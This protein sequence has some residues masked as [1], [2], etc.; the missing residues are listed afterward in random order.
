M[1]WGFVAWWRIAL[2]LWQTDTAALLL[3]WVSLQSVNDIAAAKVCCVGPGAR[4][5]AEAV[6]RVR[7][8]RSRRARAAAAAKAPRWVACMSADMPEQTCSSS[9]QRVSR[10]R[11]DVLAI[12]LLRIVLDC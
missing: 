3:S 5:E 8:V 4:G 11:Q 1:E 12:V 2:C 10:S 9:A 7:P 6:Q